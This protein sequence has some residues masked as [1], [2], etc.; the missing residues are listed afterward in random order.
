MGAV[1]LKAGSVSLT[2]LHFDSSKAAEIEAV[3]S[4][5]KTEAPA[6]F[7]NLP[8]LLDLSGLDAAV[9][10]LAQLISL[11]RDNGLLPVA[12]RNADD[13]YKAQCSELA[14][15]DL[16]KASNRRSDSSTATAAAEG[17]TEDAAAAS[18]A[19]RPVKIHTGNVRSGQQLFTDGD[20]IILG[21]VSAG[22]E[23]LA[24]GDIHIYGALRGRALAGVKGDENAVI[25]CQQFDA[26]LVAIAGQYRLF[27]D[28]PEEH[29]KTV[30]ISLN[31]GNLNI[32]SV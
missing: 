32:A 14:L 28:A 30:V 1:K 17:V 4:H 19:T 15:A 18:G 9:L 27:E 3:L 6:L 12:V 31:D 20:L 13:A 11:C 25:G 29:L 23:V 24:T 5:K 8:C 10:P 22:A 26:E 21:M 16:G 7:S 2:T